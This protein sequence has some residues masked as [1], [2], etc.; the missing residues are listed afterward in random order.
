[1]PSPTTPAPVG[2]ASQAPSNAPYVPAP[3]A[4]V[5]RPRGFLIIN[6]KKIA[7]TSLSASSTTAF[8]ASSWEA[9]LG[10]FGQPQGADLTFFEGL[11]PSTV[12]SVCYG[13]LTKGQSAAEFPKAGNYSTVMVGLVDDLRFDRSTG[14]T[15][16]HGRDLVARLIDA[17]TANRYSN[18][19]ASQAVTQIAKQ[20]GFTPQVTPTKLAIGK[21]SNDVY[22]ALSGS[23][24]YWD[25]ITAWARAE[26]FTAYVD[27]TTLYFGPP[28][29]DT[30]K[31]PWQFYLNRDANGRLWGNCIDLTLTKNS[32]LSKD[33][34]VTV[35]SHSAKTGRSIMAT[36]SRTGTK[37]PLSS[38]SSDADSVLNIVVRRP[39]LDL[40]Q[41]QA[42]ANSKL[43]ELSRWEREVSV[44]VEGHA[45]LSVQ[46][47]IQ[48]KGTD[49][50][51]DGIYFQK[52]LQRS[53]DS[54]DGFIMTIEARNIPADADDDSN[55]DSSG[56]SG[57]S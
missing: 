53:W 48:I 4:T 57:G 32:N 18:S 6:G 29:A 46:K 7:L 30:D 20:F 11:P 17:K 27:G 56:G 16:L 1:M 24:P 23:S 51:F 10:L 21:Y 36:A 8:T 15:H 55:D 54:D 45:E 25:L 35:L 3:A 9:E 12:V 43:A 19:T 26:N 42:I 50:G 44:T 34:T 14:V 22:D 5:R 38:R 52:S 39:G 47:A 37:V 28:P 33:I 2:P 40:A 13:M 31:S 49:S 41:A